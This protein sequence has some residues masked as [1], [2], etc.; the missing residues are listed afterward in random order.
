MT[1]LTNDGLFAVAKRLG[2]QT[3]P[4]VLAV[5]PQ[6]DSYDDWRDAQERATADLTAAGVL[7]PYGEVES[8]LALALFALSQPDREIVARIYATAPESA[9]AEPEST[10]EQP[11]ELTRPAGL[12]SARVVRVCVARR[13]EQH[14]AAV[15]T[16]DS[17]DIEAIWSDGSGTALARPL[18]QALGAG[19]PADVATFSAPADELA[20]RLDE[21]TTAVDYADALYALGV[22]D[23]DATVLGLAFASCR[24]YAEIVVYAHEDGSTIRSPGAIAIY[25]TGRGRVLVTAGIAPDQ[26]LW[27]TVAPGTDR[28]IAEALSTVV[29]MLPGGRW[30]TD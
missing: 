26:Q 19:T 11:T 29:E 20:Q 3:L 18:L 30:L 22:A 25:E 23:R 8:E 16:G 17:F 14:A 10:P 21:S 6:H 2:V 4:V 12:P 13:G 7:D 5:A 24:G 9:D 1:T 27:S 15:R 28:R